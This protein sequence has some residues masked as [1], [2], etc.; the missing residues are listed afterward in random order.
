MELAQSSND[1]LARLSIGL[2]PETAVVGRQRYERLRQSFPIALGPRLD[3]DLD[4]CRNA[5]HS[6][7]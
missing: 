4:Q 5:S 2:K 6:I 7:A 3:C 1:G